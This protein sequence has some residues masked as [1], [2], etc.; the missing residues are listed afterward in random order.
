VARSMCCWCVLHAGWVG[1]HLCIRR[2]GENAKSLDEE[3]KASQNRSLTSRGKA[4]PVIEQALWLLSST[5]S[6][7]SLVCDVLNTAGTADGCTVTIDEWTAQCTGT[8]NASHCLTS[9][10][11]SVCGLPHTRI[12]VLLVGW[13]PIRF[14]EPAAK[15]HAWPG[16]TWHVH[17][18]EGH[19]RHRPH[20]LRHSGNDRDLSQGGEN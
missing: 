6:A 3:I 7:L 15:L 16:A 4:C 10:Q 13:R 20:C 8:V 2:S 11:C 5:L 18:W 17:K 12:G 14:Q 1:R 19:Q 9:L